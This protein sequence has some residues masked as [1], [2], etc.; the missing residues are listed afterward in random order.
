MTYITL[1]FFISFIALPTV[2]TILDRDTDVSVCYSL[3]EEE[4]QKEV[5]EIKAHF[6]TFSQVIQND[7]FIK[8]SFI[9]PFENLSKHD[10]VF[11]EIFSP[12]P[13]LV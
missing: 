3:T 12:P 13:E 10:T 2:M 4:I 5:K 8:I 9:I 6:N 1:L 11:E 7:Y